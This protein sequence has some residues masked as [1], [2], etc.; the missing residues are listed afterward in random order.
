MY[1]EEVTQIDGTIGRCQTCFFPRLSDRYSSEY[2]YAILNYPE[3]QQELCSFANQNTRNHSPGVYIL[4]AY[5]MYML[6][7]VWLY[8]FRYVGM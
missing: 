2:G 1:V 8:R 5:D 4:H 7:M 3:E 6:C